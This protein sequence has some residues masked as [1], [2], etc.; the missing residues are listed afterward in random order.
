MIVAVQVWGAQANR[1]AASDL[2][3]SEGSEWQA[4]AESG[5]KF[6]RIDFGDGRHYVFAL[7]ADCEYHANIAY[8]FAQQFSLPA[9]W[10]VGRSTLY[11]E[12]DRWT[13]VGGGRWYV[14]QRAGAVYLYGNS[15]AYGA[16]DLD[17]AAGEMARA[18]GIA[19]HRVRA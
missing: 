10:S 6:V 4:P 13:I 7:A 16:L 19:G 9:R 3:L 1:G 2:W 12:D 5:G 8:V 11:A 17:V 18:G 15:T 14:D